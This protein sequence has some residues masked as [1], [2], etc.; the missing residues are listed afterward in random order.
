MAT[1]WNGH[2]ENLGGAVNVGG[3]NLF[4]LN[5]NKFGVLAEQTVDETTHID[6]HRTQSYTIGDAID[7]AVQRNH[8]ERQNPKATS[9][10]KRSTI[11]TD[12]EREQKNK[13]KETARVETPE[14]L[15]K[16]K[17][18]QYKKDLIALNIKIETDRRVELLLS[19]EEKR[20]AQLVHE[21]P[22]SK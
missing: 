2:V 12:D 3:L 11:D 14:L 8:I 15:K 16:T 5:S 4:C 21:H 17:E 10:D 13:G 19:A 1:S 18:H 22:R 20:E 6:Q 9:K 7:I